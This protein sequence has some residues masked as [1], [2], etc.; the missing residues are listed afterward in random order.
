MRGEGMISKIRKNLYG[1]ENE[2]E[3]QKKFVW[4]NMNELARTIGGIGC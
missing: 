2:F 1:G 3:N 4:G